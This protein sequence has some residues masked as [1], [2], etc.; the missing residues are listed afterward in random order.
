M[1]Y[2][3][4]DENGKEIEINHLSKFIEAVKLKLIDDETLLYDYE[5]TICEKAKNVKDFESINNNI[6][7][8]ENEGNGRFE[9]NNENTDIENFIDN[10]PKTKGK[11]LIGIAWFLIIFQILIYFGHFNLGHRRDPFIEL[12]LLDYSSSAIAGAIGVIIGFSLISIFAFILSIIALVFR[13]NNYGKITAIVSFIT[14]LINICILFLPTSENIKNQ[15]TYSII[16]NMADEFTSTWDKINEGEILDSRNYEENEYGEITPIMQL[17]NNW[18]VDTQSDYLDMFREIEECELAMILKPETITNAKNLSKAKSNVEKL[19]TVLGEY[20]TKIINRFDELPL[21]VSKLNISEDKIQ[22]FLSGYNK[23][24]NE[25]VD[26]VLVF[27]MIEYSLVNEMNSLLDFMALKQDQVKL[28][29]NMLLF[30]KQ[31]DTDTY[32]EYITNINTLAASEQQWL[33]SMSNLGKIKA[34]EFQEKINNPFDTE[35]QNQ[36]LPTHNFTIEFPSIFQL[37]NYGTFT[38]YTAEVEDEGVYNVFVQPYVDPIV[39]EEE[40]KSELEG[41]LQ[42][43]L[44]ILGDTT[45]L[46]KSK[47]ITYKDHKALEYEYTS[48]LDGNRIYYRGIFFIDGRI[49]YNISTACPEFSKDIVYN[50]YE[51]FVASFKLNKY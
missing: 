47:E 29:N 16:N 39:D 45:E 44:L 26:N 32:N 43:R 41:Q 34:D 25:G 38:L 33:E 51:K 35:E 40:I 21:E 3:Y 22:S 28:S 23:T 37:R 18:L 46:I 9:E 50:N 27:F 7:N 36:I 31:E 48:N 15:D 19:N 14:I 6:L 1:K 10:P 8:N 20:E 11:V 17:Y 42:G 12:L 49:N 5:N 24:K 2:K 4:I 13:K 30:T